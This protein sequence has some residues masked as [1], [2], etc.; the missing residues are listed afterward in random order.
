MK[1]LFVV[2]WVLEV[3]RAGSERYTDFVAR[4]LTEQGHEC[5]FYC[6]NEIVKICNGNPPTHTEFGAPIYFEGGAD[7]DVLASECDV[8]WTHLQMTRRAIN[9]AKRH[10][11]PLISVN[12]AD[13]QV[14]MYEIQRDEVDLMVYNSEW[15]RDNIEPE[16][17][18]KR[19]AILV[20]P[21]RCSDFAVEDRTEQRFITHL[22]CNEGKGVMMARHWAMEMPEYPFL[23]VMGNYF[24][25]YVPPGFINKHL[26]LQMPMQEID[27]P[28]NITFIPPTKDVLNDVLRRTKIA[29]VPSV[30]DS[31]GMFALECCAAGIPVIAHPDKCF[32][33]SLGRDGLFVDRKKSKTNC[34]LLTKLMEDEEFYQHHSQLALRRAQEVEELCQAQIEAL[35]Q[36]MLALV[37]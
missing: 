2:H 1:V 9:A 10:N 30:I 31:W 13:G 12:H 15:L 21:M 24:K 23:F 18:A 7:L 22:N 17:K 35:H 27:Y 34:D 4:Y 16:F 28:S 14:P 33:E 25:Q 37:P 8:I 36:Q 3:R 29:V 32:L 5:V 20:P 11:K 19:S 26:H 6:E